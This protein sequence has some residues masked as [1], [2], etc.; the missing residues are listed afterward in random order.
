MQHGAEKDGT[1]STEHLPYKFDPYEWSARV[2]V[3]KDTLGVPFTVYILITPP[4]LTSDPLAGK[5]PLDWI[6]SKYY[7]GEVAAMTGFGGRSYGSTNADV[8]AEIIEGYVSLNEKLKEFIGT[9]EPEAVEEHLRG[10]LLW[11]VGKSGRGENKEVDLS[12]LPTLEVTVFSAKLKRV[13]DDIPIPIYEDAVEHPDI[14]K[15]KQGGTKSQ[16]T[17]S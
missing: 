11:K 7:S 5:D 12:K 15:G 2:V 9:L 14:T 13:R 16:E 17:F 10:H 3:D 1:R 4:S 6:K 8:S